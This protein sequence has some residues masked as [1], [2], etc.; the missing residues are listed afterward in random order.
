MTTTVYNRDSGVVACDSRWSIL[1]E[2]GV[3]YVD[4]APFIKIE[5]AGT[6]AFVFAGKAPVIHAWKLFLRSMERGEPAEQ[7]TLEGIALLVARMGCGSLL[8]AHRQDIF[9]PNEEEADTVFAGTGSS[10]AARCWLSNKCAKRAVESAMQY[11]GNSG[12]PVRYVELLSGKHNLIAC[13]GIESLEQA[14][15]EKG[16]VMLTRNDQAK[17]PMPFKDAAEIDPAVRELYS[18][19]ATG[20]MRNEIQAPCDAVFSK[21]KPED[22]ARIGKTLRSIFG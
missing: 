20:A 21:P 3:L 7:P 2:F 5:R 12:G 17:G 22:D 14:F 10:H 8:D 4:E 19:V 16:M 6:A 18:Q 13:Q 9:L 15:L 1:G 11:D